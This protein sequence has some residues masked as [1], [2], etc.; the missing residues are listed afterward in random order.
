MNQVLA[1]KW[2]QQHPSKYLDKLIHTSKER[3]RSLLQGGRD[4]NE[5]SQGSTDEATIRHIS[6]YEGYV[7][8]HPIQG[9]GYDTARLQGLIDRKKHKGS[10]YCIKIVGLVPY[11][12]HKWRDRM[13]LRKTKCVAIPINVSVKLNYYMAGKLTGHSLIIPLEDLNN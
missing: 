2:L 6:C 11:A 13:F 1:P 5:S 4:E 3:I 12:S 10:S 9:R 8:K 7:P